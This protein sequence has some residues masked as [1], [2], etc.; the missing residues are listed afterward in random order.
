[1]SSPLFVANATPTD[2][3]PF[4]I[5]QSPLTAVYALRITLYDLP[6]FGG[7]GL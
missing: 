1:M 3:S 2:Q 6:N 4:A 5:C 7:D